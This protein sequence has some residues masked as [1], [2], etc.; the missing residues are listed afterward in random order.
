MIEADEV[1]RLLGLK[2]HPIE[3]GWFDETWRA[4]D[5]LNPAMLPGRYVGP[6]TT[7]TAIY[8]LLT[9]GAVSAL[10]RL[11]SDE[12]FH[13]YL[14]DAVEMLKLLQDGSS[15]IA[16][17]GSDL[18]AGQRPQIRVPAGA[19]QGARLLPGGRFALM[20]CTVA[21][22]FDYA[23]YEHATDMQALLSGWPDQQ[24]RIEALLRPAAS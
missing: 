1:I 19:W 11:Q 13:F 22:G 21:P 15:E 3:G 5:I 6:R 9:E 8:Y 12:I 16:A 24:K 18:A 23:D 10:H 20:G 14:G 2:P 17:L 4:G 7:G